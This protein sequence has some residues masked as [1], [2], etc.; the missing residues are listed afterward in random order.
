[1][2]I[3]MVHDGQMIILTDFVPYLVLLDYICNQV[4]NIIAD[5]TV[6]LLVLSRQ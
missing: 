6:S 3:L 2:V 5:I 4:L 1:M